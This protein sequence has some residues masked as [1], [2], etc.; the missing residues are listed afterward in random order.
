[1]H[2]DVEVIALLDL[3]ARLGVGGPELELNSLG[4][5][6]IAGHTGGA[7]ALAGTWSDALDADSAR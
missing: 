1:M 3:L 7:G 5:P 2:S 6:R 4:S